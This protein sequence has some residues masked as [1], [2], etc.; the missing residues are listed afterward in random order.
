MERKGG[1]KIITDD[2]ILG[3]FGRM[4]M[5]DG[6]VLISAIAARLA[7][8]GEYRGQTPRISFLSL[9]YHVRGLSCSRREGSQGELELQ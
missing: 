9:L 1:G 6:K 3:F 7:A 8:C 2:L 4:G 5:L